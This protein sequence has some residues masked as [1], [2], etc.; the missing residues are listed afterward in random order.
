MDNQR[1]VNLQKQVDALQLMVQELLGRVREM[2]EYLGDDSFI[3]E[4]NDS[5]DDMESFD[6]TEYPPPKLHKQ[7]QMDFSRFKKSD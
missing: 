4:R 7:K 6:D 2:E 1:N 5:G 3:D